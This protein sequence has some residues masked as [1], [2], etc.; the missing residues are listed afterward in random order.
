LT[1]D[2]EYG[3]VGY[4]PLLPHNIDI[5]IEYN[6]KTHKDELV[7]YYVQSSTAYQYNFGK[8]KDEKFEK[9][10]LIHFKF[11]QD[12]LFYPFSKSLL[13]AGRRT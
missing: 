11:K 5:R 7:Y 13:E 9:Y 3:I 8:T 10:E 4:Q 2:S 6:E 1:I 12:E